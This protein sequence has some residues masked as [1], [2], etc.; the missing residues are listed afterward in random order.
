LSLFAFD[1]E[2]H[3]IQ[4]GLLAPPLVCGSVADASSASLLSKSDARAWFREHVRS[5]HIVGTNLAFDLGVMVADDCHLLDDVFGALDDGR[6][7]DVSIRE[8]LLDIARGMYG[9][10]PKTGRKLTDDEDDGVRYSLALLA[11]RYLGLDLSK[12]KSGPDS[13]RKRYALLESV[14]LAD[15]PTEAVD[16]PKRDARHTYDVYVAQEEAAKVVTNGGNLHAEAEQVRAAFALHLMSMWG[17]RTDGRKVGELRARV[18]AEWERSRKK[19]AEVGIFREDGSKD[20]ARLKEMVTAAYAGSPPYTPASKRFPEGQIA[21]DRDTL[22]ESGDPLLE[23]LGKSGKNDKYRSTYLPA[24]EQ[25]VERPINPRFNVIVATTRTSGDYQQ[26]PQKGGIRECHHAR[27]GT[28]YCSVD[29][30]GGE[31][32]SMSQRAIWE[33]GY[34]RMAESLLA[35]TDVH[36]VAAAE[37]LGVPY[38]ELRPRVV[39]KEPEAEKFRALA[40]I[41]N[42]GKGGGLG[43]GG[44]AYN[45]RAK[46]NVRFCLLTGRAEK[47]GVERDVVIVQGKPKSVCTL[48]IRIAKELGDRWLDAWP[49]QKELFTIASRLSRGGARVDV[50]IPVANVVRGSCGYTQILNT[51]FQG[52]IAVAVKRATYRVSKEMHTDRRSSLWGSH[53]NLNVH[54]ELIA[55]L[56]TDDGWQ[57]TH[58]AAWRMTTIILEETRAVMPDLAPAVKAEPALSYIMSKGAQTLRDSKGLL[59]PW[60]PELVWLERK[61]SA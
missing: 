41:F 3:L 26:L 23:A 35:G 8:A 21:T 50:T 10:D 61:K 5:S 4:P 28:V 15:W 25:G 30:D 40:K 51:P 20:T 27:P 52:L 60:E 16:Y 29:L 53:L 48:C 44:M 11:E 37:F 19:F 12:D 33:L 6:L 32:R 22:V 24:I 45:A 38:E 46:D 18:D 2:T 42:F 57:R 14:P 47:C 56:R 43:A 58:D 39:A 1:C 59:W 54:D 9:V 31:L 34:S 13:W 17:L 36:T 55:E 7:H 49:E